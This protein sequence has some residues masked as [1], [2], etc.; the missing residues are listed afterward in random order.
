MQTSGYLLKQTLELFVKNAGL[1]LTD[2]ST[3]LISFVLN[4]NLTSELSEPDKANVA[5]DKLRILHLA[6]KHGGKDLGL[7]VWE[8]I[9]DVVVEPNNVRRAQFK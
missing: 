8:D 3:D 6:K 7:G 4:H 2:S 9:R 5:L 1:S